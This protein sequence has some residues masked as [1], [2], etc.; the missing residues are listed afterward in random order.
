MS[1][2]RPR[3]R[4]PDNLPR[5]LDTERID[6]IKHLR[7]SQLPLGQSRR[8]DP[9][10]VHMPDPPTPV[11]NDTQMLHLQHV[12]IERSIVISRNLLARVVSPRN[13]SAV[14]VG[15]EKHADDVASERL[16]RLRP[17]R[18][19]D[20]RPPRGGL[21][22]QGRVGVR[23]APERHAEAEATPEGVV[24]E[25]FDPVA[26]CGVGVDVGGRYPAGA[27][28]GEPRAGRQRARGDGPGGW[29]GWGGAADVE[30]AGGC[31]PDGHAGS[32][33]GRGR[34]LAEGFRREAIEAGD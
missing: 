15:R 3:Q 32:E 5:K 21:A 16:R 26:R 10:L 19:G 1:C 34:V 31:E 28:D 13:A 12:Q 20:E 17:R 18:R 8:P 11:D 24:R 4:R 7:L 30:A 2:A 29:W 25:G 14:V 9:L 33:D 27:G 6:S 22:R 23:Y